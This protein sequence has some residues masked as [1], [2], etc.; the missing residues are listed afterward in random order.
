MSQNAL[1]QAAVKETALFLGL[2]FFGFVLMPI[3][4]Y[5]VG[6][7][8]FGRYGGYGYGDFFGTLSAKIRSGDLVAWFFIL[9]PYLAWQ[10]LRLTL[11][12]WRAT[13]RSPG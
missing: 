10:T 11:F 5:W 2:L 7:D 8:V 1:K 13:R 6:Q 3:A 9:S 12:A 4:I